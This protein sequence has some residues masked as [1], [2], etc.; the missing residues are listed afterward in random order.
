VTSG[1]EDRAADWAG[2]A[3]TEGHDSYRAYRETL[4]ECDLGAR[5]YDE[6]SRRPSS[7]SRATPISEVRTSSAM[8]QS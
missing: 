4:F 3:R 7:T 1:F 2:F 6:I 8:L 5:G